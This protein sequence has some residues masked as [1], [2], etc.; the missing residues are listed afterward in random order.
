MDGT[1][2]VDE[3]YYCAVNILVGDPIKREFAPI[4]VEW[5]HHRAVEVLSDIEKPL[6]LFSAS[7]AQR[8]SLGNNNREASLNQTSFS[9]LELLTH[10]TPNRS[11]VGF[12]QRFGRIRHVG[13]LYFACYI[14]IALLLFAFCSVLYV[15]CFMLFIFK[16]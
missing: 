8:V 16:L 2:S 5:P 11:L 14:S 13:A 10:R 6:G 3:H 7:V 12:L 4:K 9:V 15:L 1:G